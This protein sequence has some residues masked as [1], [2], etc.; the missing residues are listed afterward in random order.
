MRRHWT[1]RTGAGSCLLVATPALA[2]GNAPATAGLA[3]FVSIGVGCIGGALSGWRGWRRWPSYA[4][5]VAASGA[6]T[7]ATLVLLRPQAM[8]E[9]LLGLL[10]LATPVAAIVLLVCHLP[11][12]A[13]GRAVAGR[14][15]IRSERNAED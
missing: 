8:H 1:A 15:A 13:L 11:A 14:T 9:G 7:V 10:F 5:G 3:L 2:S 6:L 4:G 12:H